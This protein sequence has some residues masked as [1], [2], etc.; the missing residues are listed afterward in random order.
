MTPL[1]FRG[2][3]GRVSPTDMAHCIWLSAQGGSATLAVL[4]TGLSEHTVLELFRLS[5]RIMLL[6]APFI[7]VR[8]LPTLSV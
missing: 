1:F 4:E 3:G 8:C 2:G 5:R 6:L 7:G